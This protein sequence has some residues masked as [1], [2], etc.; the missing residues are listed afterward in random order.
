VVIEL[1]GY[2]VRIGGIGHF[3]GAGCIGEVDGDGSARAGGLVGMLPFGVA[4]GEVAGLLAELLKDNGIVGYGERPIG[5][6][7][8]GAQWGIVRN[9]GISGAIIQRKRQKKQDREQVIHDDPLSKR[10]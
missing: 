6:I 7:S 9:E 2:G 3:I 5:F 10:A 8:D 1:N 4:E